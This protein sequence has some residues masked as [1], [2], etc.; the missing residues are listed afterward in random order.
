EDPVRLV[1]AVRRAFD[2]DGGG[3]DGGPGGDAPI[4]GAPLAAL[5]DLFAELAPV[6]A[7]LVVDD[8][9]LLA[10]RPGCVE[11]LAD[12]V[13]AAPANLPLVLPGRDLPA[14]PL[15]RLRAA[16]EVA[17]V[18]EGDL[19]FS[20]AEV[21]ALATGLGVQVPAAD[22]GGWPALVRLAAAAPE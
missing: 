12:L 9:E 11:L 5:L 19:R 1:A 2:G 21:A 13:R 7:V 3:D 4:P 17:E 14:L 18:T 16:G 20:P 22:V 10:D 8:A 15:A 6:D